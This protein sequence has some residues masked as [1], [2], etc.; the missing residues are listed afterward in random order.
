[1]VVGLVLLFPAAYPSA[2]SSGGVFALLAA[3]SLAGALLARRLPAL[4]P[5]ILVL[6]AAGLLLSVYSGLSLVAPWLLPEDREWFLIHVDRV[7]LGYTWEAAW[8]WLQS[9]ALT[10]LMQAV[11]TSFYAFPLVLAAAL[12]RR[13]DWEG[14]YGGLD[15]LILGFLISYCGYLLVPAR[16]PYEFL[17]FADPLPTLGLQP[18]LHG[19]IILRSLTKRDCFPSGH[20]MMS[21]YV[22]WL[23]WVRVREVLWITLPW[24]LLTVTATLYLRYHYL[25]DV[26]AGVAAFAIYVPLSNFL[27]GSF[28]RPATAGADA[29]GSA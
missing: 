1:M 4:A 14:L 5:G 12:A 21:L 9:P 7:A 16:S 6:G 25:I 29:T 23:S 27:F 28:R 11:Y 15:R 3:V 18:V 10:D 19:E 8:S 17:E 20:T 13:R 22:A 24:A 2:G 26:L